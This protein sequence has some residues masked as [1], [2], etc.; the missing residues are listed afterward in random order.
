MKILMLSSTFPYPPTRGGTQ[1]R[2]FNLMKYLTQRHHVTLVTQRA[3]DVTDEEVEALRAWVEELAIFPRPGGPKNDGI[4][5]KVKRFSNFM[6]EGT[7]PSVLHN[8]VPEM[9]QFVDRYVQTLITAD[10]ASEFVIT[11]EH[12]ANEIYLR[13]EW[14]GQVNSVVDIHSSVYATCRQQLE[15]G[16]AEKQWRD[17]LQLPLLRQYERDYCAK[18]SAIAVTTDEDRQQI[19]EFTPESKIK[20]IPNGVDLSRF[21]YR[22]SDPGGK[23]IAFVGAMDNLPNIDA[24]R[25]FALEVFP[26]VR[27][28]YPDATL[29]L[30][31]A[32]P[33]SEILELGEQPGVTVTGQVPSVVEYLH[34]SAVCVV[35]MRTGYG[36]KNKTLEAM[37]AG[38]PVVASD[39]GLE[40]LRV[41]G[42]GVPLRALRA[43]QVSEYVS[44]ISRLF[45]QRGLREKLAKNARS[46]VESEF[47]WEVAGK[48]YEKLL[49]SLLSE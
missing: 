39:R 14:Q 29:M 28:R 2:T 8:Y 19:Q 32:R 10:V 41:D 45:E 48:R 25:F 42:E 37:A 35:P 11:C 44:A 49:Q 47:T 36:I 20:V 33:G 34:K 40:G 21:T 5:G 46:L 9:Q 17:R 1:V 27:L 18:F 38:T 24:V 31:G 30:V 6:R 16:T 22:P 23:Q 13:P 4:W 43:N 15:T 26:L 7:P 3:E 12:S